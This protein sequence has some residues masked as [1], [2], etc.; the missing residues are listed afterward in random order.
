MYNRTY[1]YAI[2]GLIAAAFASTAQASCGQAFCTVNTDWHAQ[3][4]WSA[5]G[6]RADLRYEFVDQDQLR[7]GTHKIAPAGPPADPDSESHDEVRTINRNWVGTLSY[8]SGANWGASLVVPVASRA[9][10]HIHHVTDALGDAESEV[11]S[12]RFDKLGDVR[13][14]GRYEFTGSNIGLEA[15]LK[16]PTG[17]TD[18]RNGA[19][20]AA[21]RSLQPGTGTT[22]AIVGGYW[23][24]QAL[25]GNLFAHASAQFA[26]NEHDGFRPGQRFGI[27][28]G[29]TRNIAA[30]LALLLQ[31][32][33]HVKR[34]DR[35]VNAEP[36]DSGSRTLSVSPG[37]SYAFARDF[38]VYGLVE[39]P[40]Y[41]HVNGVQLASD[42][43][44]ALGVSKAF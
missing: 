26:L 35:G 9:H 41:R 19:G 6:W 14:I 15:G 28:V 7:S 20:E 42:W 23:R 37:L 31:A 17:E 8:W 21:E 24:T 12:W 44:L 25:G 4:V 40:V 2:G 13:A 39:L 43:A 18:V 27:D 10:T 34:R 5:P 16:L 30:N 33:A 32:N 11:E 29:Y 22:D 3:G 38:Q 1:R 36:E